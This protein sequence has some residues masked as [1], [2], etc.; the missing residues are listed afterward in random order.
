MEQREQESVWAREPEPE[1]GASQGLLQSVL[2]RREQVEEPVR[3]RERESV[4]ELVPEQEL[5]PSSNPEAFLLRSWELEIE[6]EESV[7]ERE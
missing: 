1:Q 3:A 5:V 7:P 6:Q 2:R 4:Q